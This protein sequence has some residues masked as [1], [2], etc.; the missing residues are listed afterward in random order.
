M[1]ESMVQANTERAP[2]SI[3]VVPTVGVGIVCIRTVGQIFKS[4]YPPGS[5]VPSVFVT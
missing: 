5:K 1:A 4:K 2:C 3:T